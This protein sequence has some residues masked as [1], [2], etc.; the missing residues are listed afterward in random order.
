MSAVA[1]STDPW[2]SWEA[3]RSVR[4]Q[5]RTQAEVLYV[6]RRYGPATHPRIYKRVVRN[7]GPNHSES[8][9]RT[10]VSELVEMGLV[11]DSGKTKR[12]PSGRRAIVWKATKKRK[13][14]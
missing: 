9:T 6:L 4:G 1:R 5:T 2:T 11:K 14:T 10:R 7:F 8:G 12:L 13:R 3:A